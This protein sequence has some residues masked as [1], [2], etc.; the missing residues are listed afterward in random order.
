MNKNISERFSFE[1]L[2][3]SVYGTLP[4]LVAGLP[5]SCRSLVKRNFFPNV[6][7]PSE[8]LDG[9]IP[10]FTIYLIAESYFKISK[11]MTEKQLIENL[12]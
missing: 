4:T 8:S 3:T 6:G 9:S 7:N 2:F 11:V 5:R 1:I 12:I 10:V